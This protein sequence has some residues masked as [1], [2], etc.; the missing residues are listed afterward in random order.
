MKLFYFCSD[1]YPSGTGFAV[2]FVNFIQY[3]IDENKYEHIY[4]YCLNDDA[5][6][7]DCFLGKAT[8]IKFDYRGELRLAK[9]TKSRVVLDLYANIKYKKLY[10]SLCSFDIADEDSIFYEEFY[11]GNLKN[12]L[13]KKFKKNKHI[14]RV[15][16]TM[17]E[18]VMFDGNNYFRKILFEQAIKTKLV[19]ATTTTFY[20]SFL[21]KHLFEDKYSLIKNID[22]IILPNSIHNEFLQLPSKNQTKNDRGSLKLLQ[23]GR[24]DEGGY[25]QK[26]FS[27]TIK[28]LLYLENSDEC[29]DGYVLTVIGSGVM[30]KDFL[31]Q[32]KKLKK[33]K[34][35]YFSSLPNSE[36]REKIIN[37]DVVLL[38]SRCEG[39]SMFAVEAL[40]LGKAIITTKNSGVKDIC[41]NDVNALLFDVYDYVA[42]AKLLSKIYN[43]RELISKFESN[44]STI[45]NEN[46]IKL[47]SGIRE[48]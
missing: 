38:P 48:L 40:S 23:L 19:I 37:T 20:I 5:V 3:V 27:D 17:P 8:L 18:F 35:E 13:S 34:I 15:H 29:N 32:A 39:M 24:M 7:P 30:S 43:N 10:K 2:S 1:F 46:E 25:F 12:Y 31:E 4:I 47:K 41:L 33:T 26:G 36:V 16:G 9:L 44:C 22:Y 42:Y 45:Y 14:I 11:F 28:A 6:L 21:N